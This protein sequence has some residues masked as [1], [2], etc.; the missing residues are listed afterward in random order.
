MTI[1]CDIDATILAFPEFFKDFFIAMKL[2]GNSVGI[3]TA[4]PASQKED[5]LK[6]LR[7]IGIDPD[8]YVARPD[9]LPE[10]ISHGTFKADACNKLGVDVIFDDFDNSDNAMVADFFCANTRTIPFTSWG[11]NN[12]LPQE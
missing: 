12:V 9:D 8:F 1:A 5:D 10:S 11:F 3:V 7:Q 4:R 2:I 6:T